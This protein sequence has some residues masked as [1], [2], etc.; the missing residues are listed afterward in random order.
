M[1]I[2]VSFVPLHSS[3]FSLI[4]P[5]TSVRKANG[6]TSY[7]PKL[8]IHEQEL[9]GSYIAS[10]LFHFPVNVLSSEPSILAQEAG[11]RKTSVVLPHV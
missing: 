9:L 2:F 7:V 8:G 1:Y 5:K 11:Y 10:T 6:Q 3:F 4:D